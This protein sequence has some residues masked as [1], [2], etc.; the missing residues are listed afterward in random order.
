MGLDPARILGRMIHRLRNQRKEV[1]TMAEILKKLACDPKCGFMI[2]S[3]NEK[4]II[5]IAIQHAKK[6]HNMQV[7]EKEAK[8]MIKDA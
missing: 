2:Q 4:E 8:A 3:H 7:T 1:N 6:S 5:D